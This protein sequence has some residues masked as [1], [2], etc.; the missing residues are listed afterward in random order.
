VIDVG[1]AVTVGMLSD[2]LQHDEEGAK[3]LR[4]SFAT[5]NE[6]L[7]ANG[8][9]VHSEPEISFPEVSRCTIHGYPY[10]FI[11]YLRRV[12]A[13]VA[14]DPNW[15]I[16]P[17][18][19]DEDPAEDP[20]VEEVT[21]QLESHLLCHSDAEGFY[22]P[23]D[24]VDV[25]CATDELDVPGGMLCSSFQLMREL[26]T[27]APTLGIKLNG[28]VLEDSEAGRLNELVEKE[29]A[30]WVET[31][32]WLSLFEAARLSLKYKTAIVFA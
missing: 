32:V 11:H 27:M 20:I 26:T 25:L 23:V 8:L 29:A 10:S 6:L 16:K 19:D 13:H 18:G 28:N 9:P 14:L 12:Y 2:L 30:F 1:L 17:T 15:Q 3:W 24:F 5:C 7:L 31:C 22:L 21:D 4:G